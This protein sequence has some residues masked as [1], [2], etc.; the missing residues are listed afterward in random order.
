MFRFLERHKREALRAQPFP[1]AWREILDRDVAYVAKLSKAD[2]TE[3]E[4][5]VQVFLAEKNLEG[6]GGLELTDEIRVTIAAHACLLLLHRET[7]IYPDLETVLVYPH[8]YRAKGTKR[9]GPVVIES[10][11]ARLG[12]SWTRGVVVL[13]WDH[14]SSSARHLGGDNVVL[15]EFAHQLD[16]ED[17][18]MDGAPDLGSRARFASWARVL[19]EEF[20][21]LSTRLHAGRPS[22]IDA[23]G[24]TSPP[25]FFAVV[26][27]M[28]FEK[29]QQLR[30]RH[31][32]LY[33]ELAAF[34][35]QDPAGESSAT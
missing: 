12:E 2:R 14:V 35:R 10:D 5:L 32:E 29:P 1:E 17:G 27:E 9:D 20:A 26:T 25:E 22:D 31:P 11:D 15:H 13:A 19:G 28:F 3:L 24:A 8:A 23:Y 34:Y 18:S 33:A 16:A 6:C 21:E 7:D 30:K 4:G